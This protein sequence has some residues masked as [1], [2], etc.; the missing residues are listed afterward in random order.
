M[1]IV[2]T[3]SPKE[4]SCGSCVCL[5]VDE[6][7][8]LGFDIVEV[9]LFKAYTRKNIGY[10]WAIQQGASTIF[11]TDGKR[12]ISSNY[13]HNRP[14]SILN[15]NFD[16]WMLD[17]NLP[18]SKNIVFESATE[19]VIAYCPVN[20]DSEK[21]GNVYAHFGRPD[22]WPRG[23]PL[24]ESNVRRPVQYLPSFNSLPEHERQIV[25]PPPLVQQGLA[26]LDPDVDAI[27][28]LTQGREQKKTK[29]CKMSPS[30]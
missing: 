9:T 28:R 29:F 20:E 19:S 25:A 7:Q 1:V 2:D 5:S 21:G 16:S 30:V 23:F 10:L 18:T 4:W 27:F 6:Q 14:S 17:D 8:C 3:K 12:S 13:D 11:D 15:D 24:S 22:V 26:D